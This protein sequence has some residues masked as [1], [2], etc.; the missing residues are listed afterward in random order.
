MANKHPALIELYKLL[1]T[2]DWTEFCPEK[3]RKE[4]LDKWVE[5]WMVSVST[6]QAV[7]HEKYLGSEYSDILKERMAQKLAEKL[8]EDCVN[9]TSKE[10]KISA[11]MIGIKRCLVKN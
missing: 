1:E 8:A 2:R 9:Y 7:L 5:K 3:N 10:R 6:E 4:L 11:Q